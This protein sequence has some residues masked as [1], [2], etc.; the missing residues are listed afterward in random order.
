MG[1]TQIPTINSRGRSLSFLA[2]V[3]VVIGFVV[4]ALCGFFPRWPQAVS[5]A[6]LGIETCALI[7]GLRAWQR[8]LAKMAVS[9]AA[10]FIAL[11]LL[12]FFYGPTVQRE[13][14]PTATWMK[15]LET[16]WELQSPGKTHSIRTASDVQKDGEDSL[17]FEIRG[18]ERWVDTTFETTYR[19]EIATREYAPV[20]STKWYS[21]S[22][23]FPQDFPVEENR[24][25]FAQWHTGRESAGDLPLSPPL[26]LY[27]QSGNLKI[28]LRH[29]DELP[30]RDAEGV[31]D[32]R[33]FSE[34]FPLG[35]WHDFVVQ[36]KWSWQPDGFVNI[37]W[38]NQQIVEYRGPVGY[39][40]KTG[41]QFKFGLYRDATERT[42]VA[43]LNQVK[44]GDSSSDVGF[45]PSTAARYSPTEK[46]QK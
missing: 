3:L 28:K 11:S 33:L 4:T 16:T 36:A 23:Y 17:R 43:Y 42:Y 13:V 19:S 37:W 14:R 44:A 20:S 5:W 8:R 27:F 1:D 46:Q 9:G 40:R 38:N 24:L 39:R 32:E 45:D 25:V 7:L 34:T 30:V 31:P 29:S 12:L 6:A 2:F 21:F 15:P 18:G 26:A 35:Q 41:A 22:V 10:V